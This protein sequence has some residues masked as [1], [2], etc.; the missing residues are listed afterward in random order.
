[1]IVV[2]AKNIDSLW[3]KTMSAIME[4]GEKISGI[5]EIPNLVLVLTENFRSS[6]FFDTEFRKAFGDER[7]D[8][9]K[10]VTFVRPEMGMTE[11]VYKQNDPGAKWTNS[12][13]GRMISWQGEVNQIES[14]IKKLKGGKN[15]KM[16][17]IGVYDPKSD[18]KKVMGGVPCLSSIDIK[19][20]NDKLDI[21]AFFR[22]MR[23]SKAGYADVA[24]LCDLGMWLCE[25]S[26][27][28]LELGSITCIATSG[29]IFYSGDEFR[30]AKQLLDVL[31]NRSQ[32]RK[33][34]KT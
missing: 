16:I 7:I 25:R 4:H 15:T 14:A 30:Q 20:R 8:Y 24:A 32:S 18:H 27:S 33:G 13:W 23:F 17:S 11:P 26:G 19:P 34:K 5:Q 1:M 31:N 21:T 6:R 12:Y 28:K 10:S 29:H 22:S 2:E 3:R 9:A